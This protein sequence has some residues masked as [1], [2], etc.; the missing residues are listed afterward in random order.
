[1]LQPTMLERVAPG[2]ATV[3][4]PRCVIAVSVGVIVGGAMVPD[5]LEPIGKQRVAQVVDNTETHV[6]A[7][8][9]DDESIVSVV[10]AEPQ[11]SSDAPGDIDG[12]VLPHDDDGDMA[13]HA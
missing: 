5:A 11:R 7:N 2:A 12:L 4:A 9:A 10:S 6:H 13:G 8:A 3:L 1:M